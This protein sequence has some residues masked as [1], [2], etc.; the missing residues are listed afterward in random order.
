MQRKR[1]LTIALAIALPA[2][3]VAGTEGNSAPEDQQRGTVAQPRAKLR[4]NAAPAAAT[5][6]GEA[7][8]Q[9]SDEVAVLT[10]SQGRIVIQFFP[11]VA[12]QHVSNFKSLAQS[13][14]FD[15]TT[16]HRVIPG[17]MIQGGDP[18]SKND[19]LMD[20]GIGRGPRTL[21][22]EFSKIRHGRGVVSAARGQDPNSASCQFFIVVAPAAHL[23]GQYSA[24]GQVVAGME[25]A[26][27][28][29]ALPRNQRDNPGKAALV[30]SITIE[31]ASAALGEEFFKK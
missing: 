2:V 31:P 9:P 6:P 25:V 22:A 21:P 19:N 3:I 17:F 10:T 26:D 14:F 4:E 8:L 15:G 5:A 18:N 1:L 27:K 28:I 29:V 24:F 20:D 11:D 23:D 16:F 12:P 13:K 7:L 30:E